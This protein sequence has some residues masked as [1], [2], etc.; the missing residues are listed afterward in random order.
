MFRFSP[1]LVR[2]ST[3]LL[4]LRLVTVPVSGTQQQDARVAAEESDDYYKKW[5][6]QDVAYIIQADE[7]SVFSA[8]TT[9]EEKDEFIEQFWRRRDPDLSS[10][11]NE[12]REEHYRR[13]AFVNEYFGSGIP[14][15]K[16]DR[17]RIYIM[18]GE[19][20]QREYHAGGENYQ[21]KP[22]EGGGLTNTYPFELWRYR[23]I[24]GLGQDIEIEFVDRSWTG[25]FKMAMFPWE[26]DML[27]NID[28]VGQ[29]WSERLNLTSRAQR[30]GLH[31]GNLNNTAYMAKYMGQRFQDRPFERLHRYYTL[32]KPPPIK[33][34]ELQTVIDT[35]VSY[36]M[37]PFSSVDFHVWIDDQTAFVPITIEVPNRDLSFFP[38]GD[39]MKAR[40]GIYGRVTAM[41]GEVVYEFDDV[42]ARE[43]KPEHLNI[44]LTQKSLYQKGISLAPGRYKLE[45]VLKDM[46]SGNIGTSAKSLRLSAPE[47]GKL[48]SS[49]IVLAKQVRALPEV[50]DSVESFVIGDVRVVPSIDRR[51]DQS[52]EMGVYLQVYN[53]NLDSATLLPAVSIDYSVRKGNELLSRLTDSE[54]ASIQYYS[55]RRIVVVRK[56]NLKLLGE[57]SFTL[58]VKLTDHIS[59]QSVTEHAKFKVVDGG[60][61]K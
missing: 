25:E 22:Y 21:R 12:Y 9:P 16:T 51:F 28:E 45:L 23:E 27:L 59:N 2:G 30:P 35:N 8:L 19:P 36:S 57:G 17:G 46:T 20:A 3:I 15:W 33:Q 49:P 5:L 4:L 48:S 26:K 1:V 40:V 11:E 54:G 18:F 32:Q 38:S 7:R 37:L 56:V 43:Y 61:K 6:D 13:I 24:P 44:G 58:S 10:A 42:V 50:P 41:L 14:G 52:E 60:L 29:T 39:Q 47:E 34:K 31:P 55:S 53:P